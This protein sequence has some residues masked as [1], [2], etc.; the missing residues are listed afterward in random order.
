[1]LSSA[2][3]DEEGGGIGGGDEGKAVAAFEEVGNL[4][5]ECEGKNCEEGILRGEGCVVSVVVAW[6]G[7]TGSFGWVDVLG[8]VE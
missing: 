1:M 2:T 3:S 8:W 5:G 4:Y 6:E 7:G